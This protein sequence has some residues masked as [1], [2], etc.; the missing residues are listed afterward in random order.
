MQIAIRASTPTVQNVTSREN[1]RIMLNNIHEISDSV[2]E[3][4]LS[5]EIMHHG[6]KKIRRII[7]TLAESE[8]RPSSRDLAL[9][10]E[11]ELSAADSPPSAASGLSCRIVT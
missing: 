4:G 9:Q 2:E 8:V 7:L 3:Q 6:K 5:K 1:S 11:Q 10:Q